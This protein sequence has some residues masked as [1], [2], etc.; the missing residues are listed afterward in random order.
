MIFS[1]IFCGLLS[2]I[3]VLGGTFFL[4]LYTTDRPNVLTFAQQRLLITL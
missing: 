4:R 3:F 1:V 2:G